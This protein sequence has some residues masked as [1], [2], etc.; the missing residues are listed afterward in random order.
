MEGTTWTTVMFP[1]MR[2][3]LLTLMAKL[4]PPL[5]RTSPVSSVKRPGLPSR[6][7]IGF[8]LGACSPLSP[9]LAGEAFGA[10]GGAGVPPSFAGLLTAAVTTGWGAASLEFTGAGFEADSPAAVAEASMALPLRSGPLPSASAVEIRNRDDR[11]RIT[12]RPGNLIHS[13]LFQ[14]RPIENKS[15]TKLVRNLRLWGKRRTTI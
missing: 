13:S 3:N 5:G 7:G 4:K 11:I 8:H 9:R 10:G 12:A 6:A 15:S 2:E 1:G 14:L